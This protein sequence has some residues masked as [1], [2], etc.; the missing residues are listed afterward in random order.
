MA[1]NKSAAGAKDTA[2]RAIPVIEEVPDAI[3]SLGK[4][5]KYVKKSEGQFPGARKAL[6]PST[7]N[8]AIA[9]ERR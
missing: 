9:H 5:V 4:E 3:D 1:V 8:A 2:R 7:K 6:E